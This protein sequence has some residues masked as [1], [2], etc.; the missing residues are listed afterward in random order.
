MKA[1][2]RTLS[3]TSMGGLGF[4][5][6]HVALIRLY[7]IASHAIKPMDTRNLEQ[8]VLK[9]LQMRACDAA[10]YIHSG[11][12]GHPQKIMGGLA[13]L[14]SMMDKTSDDFPCE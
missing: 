9:A 2:S 4:I 10:W 12:T 1:Y 11:L 7:A 13:K 8:E 5:G 14:I 6:F 3:F